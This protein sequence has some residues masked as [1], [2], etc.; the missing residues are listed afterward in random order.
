[1]TFRVSAYDPSINAYIWDDC[2]SQ[3][4]AEIVARSFW[5]SGYISIGIERIAA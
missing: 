5:H 2:F 4:E 1:M 3:V